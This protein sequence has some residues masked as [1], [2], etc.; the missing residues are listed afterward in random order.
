MLE[1]N[2]LLIETLFCLN[3]EAPKKTKNKMIE[4]KNLVNMIQTAQQQERII[5]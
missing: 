1:F 2:S 3:K 5:K 4:K